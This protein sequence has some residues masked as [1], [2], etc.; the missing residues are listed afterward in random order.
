MEAMAE[1]LNTPEEVKWNNDNGAVIK[2]TNNRND[3]LVIDCEKPHAAYLD[4][5]TWAPCA[6]SIS[7][8]AFYP[9]LG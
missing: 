1:M 8:D 2:L 5:I 9:C 4:I 7:D 6:G 3:W